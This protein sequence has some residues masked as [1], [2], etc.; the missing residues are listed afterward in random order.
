MSA[1]PP[2]LELLKLSKSFGGIQALRGVSLSVAPGSVHALLGE[3]GA[4]KSTLVKVVTGLLPPDAGDIRMDGVP[5]AFAS[6]LDARRAGIVAVYQDPKMF[7]HLDVAENIFMGL[8]P[9]TLGGLIDRPR[10]YRRAKELLRGL[11][12]SL[13]PELLVAGLSVGELQFVEFARA[14]AESA[15]RLLFLDEPTASLSPS[16]T[17]RLFAV[18]RRLRQGGASV[19]IIS[20][21][22]EE[23]RDLVD[24]VTILRD[25][26]H[27]VTRSAADLP[28]AEIVRLMVG[29]TI[30]AAAS[31]RAPDTKSPPVLQVAGL[32]RPGLFQDI[33]FD[34]RAGEIA[35]MFGLVGAGRTEIAHALFGIS[36]AETGRV[37]I[38]GQD[39][40]PRS[41]RAMLAHGLAYLPEDRERQGLVADV[42]IRKNLAV[43]V[44]DRL[45]RL[46]ILR[47]APED[48][49][50]ARMIRELSI[51]A[52]GAEAP[53]R[54][55]SGGNRQKVVLGKWLAT[56]PRVLILDEPTHGI[57][58]GAKAQV[59][60]II[61]TLARQGVAILV[62]SSDL[63]E[64][65]ALSHHV[66]VVAAGE[67]VARLPHGEASEERIMAAA[68]RTARLAA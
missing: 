6:P 17:A 54:S 48:A 55:L 20:H 16:E 65:L 50:A 23:L 1:A 63:P 47:R 13:N 66:L 12:C 33:S 22:L 31:T 45:S 30:V 24:T 43:T 9:T 36:P 61:L 35:G 2:R 40:A 49:L 4:G 59:H 28:D 56:A 14:L 44:L 7:P 41:P 21:R 57:D 34:L 32:S 11:D 27:V 19:V 29:R 68:A 37:R 62:I 42:S 46:G 53:V 26:A 18:I 15:D 10:M 25:G 51:R 67:I 8:H 5:R 39:V 60:Q 58:V 64:I 38:A 3:N 52:G